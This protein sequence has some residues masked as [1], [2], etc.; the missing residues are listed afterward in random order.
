[1]NKLS[2]DFN[3]EEFSRKMG[4]N[5]KRPDPSQSG[6]DF[7][8]AP[9]VLDALQT[10]ELLQKRSVITKPKSIDSGDGKPTPNHQEKQI[11]M[12]EIRSETMLNEFTTY[13]DRNII[14]HLEHRVHPDDLE[15]TVNNWK[16]TPPEQIVSKVAEYFDNNRTQSSFFKDK[17]ALLDY[18]RSNNFPDDEKSLEIYGRGLYNK[19]RSDSLK[20]ALTFANMAMGTADKRLTSQQV[21]DLLNLVEDNTVPKGIMLTVTRGAPKPLSPVGNI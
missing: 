20:A 19:Y 18:A 13:L 17:K 15:P 12:D 3:P 5:I 21:H 9:T 16:N 6:D 7:G 10:R 11:S 2:S 8:E 14:T 1:M 4:F